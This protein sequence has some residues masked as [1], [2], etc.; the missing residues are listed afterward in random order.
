MISLFNV[1]IRSTLRAVLRTVYVRCAPV[2]LACVAGFAT[3]RAACGRLSTLRSDSHGRSPFR[4]WLQLVFF[5]HGLYTRDLNPIRTAPMLGTHKARQ[6][7]AC[8]HPLRSTFCK[9]DMLDR[10]TAIEGCL[11]GCAVGDSICL[12]YEGIAPQRVGRMLK[13]PLRHR[14]FFGCGMVS[15]DTDHSVFVGQCL[16]RNPTDPD[17]FA[18]S[19][20]WRLRFWL[21][22]LPAG[23]GMATLKSILRLWCGVQFSRSGV[24]SAGNGAAMRS[25]I[26][27]VVHSE[28][29]DLRHRFTQASSALTHSDPKAEFGARA[30]ADLAA[31]VS[32]D[33][34]RPPISKLEE[35]LW[36]AGEGD[37]WRDTIRRAVAACR[38]GEIRD[39]V[40]SA[41]LKRGVSGYILH[42]LPVAVASWY[43]HF[44]DFR[45][46]IEAVAMLGGDT[47]TVAAIAGSLAGIS[48]ARDGIPNDWVTGIIDRPHGVAY[49]SELA[50]TLA[51]GQTGN[52]G[53]S[54]LLFPRGILFTV[55]VLCHGFRRLLPPY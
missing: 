13:L 26:I 48:C 23:I 41:G 9:E 15:D 39:A 55:S 25:A 51:S 10:R 53:F 7:S 44:G 50:E 28:D 37:E 17:Q 47:D 11:L 45:K 33:G 32:R 16:A 22:C 43:I 24:F 4:R 46:T 2:R 19:L 27:G 12:P 8:S 49:I 3:L 54:W 52:T 31:C 38:S 5:F 21:L 6:G 29:S 36:D 40:T 35:I 18:R 30:I 20:A 42:T 14:F 34:T 1:A